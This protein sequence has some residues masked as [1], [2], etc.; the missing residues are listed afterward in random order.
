MR[1]AMLLALGAAT[2]WAQCTVTTIDDFQTGT[3][4]RKSLRSG[5][6]AQ[7]QSGAGI[8]DGLRRVIWFAGPPNTSNTFNQPATLQIAQPRLLIFSAGPEVNWAITLLWGHDGNGFVPLNRNFT[9]CNNL[10]VV[11]SASDLGLVAIATLFTGA[12]FTTSSAQVSVAQKPSYGPPFVVD[13][14]FSSFTPAPDMS[15]V[16]AVA[17]DLRAGGPTAGEDFVLKSISVQP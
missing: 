14:P 6:D 13:I 4:A 5:T 8:I 15:D 9:G 11:V 12:G 2:V 1:I 3:Y 10:R 16:K 7:N 17:L